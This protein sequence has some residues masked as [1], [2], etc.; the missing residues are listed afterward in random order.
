MRLASSALF[1]VTVFGLFLQV[2][3]FNFV[4]ASKR[5]IS[6]G[7][8]MD[9]HLRRRSVFPP[10]LRPN[11]RLSSTRRGSS[12]LHEQPG[13]A[14]PDNHLVRGR[15]EGEVAAIQRSAA[16]SEPGKAVRVCVQSPR[17]EKSAKKLMIRNPREEELLRKKA[18]VC[19]VHI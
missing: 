16:G 10:L 6:V 1:A 8:G 4:L 19:T 7:V 11:A 5:G 9:T 12:H 2:C 3:C 18:E 13:E 17:A 15:E 14:L